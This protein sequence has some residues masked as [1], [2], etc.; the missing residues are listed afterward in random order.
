MKNVNKL[1]V[2]K[3]K[4]ILNNSNKQKLINILN[5]YNYRYNISINLLNDVIF[6]NNGNN[7]QKEFKKYKYSCYNKKQLINK[8]LLAYFKL[9]VVN[10]KLKNYDNRKIEIWFLKIAHANCISHNDMILYS[11]CDNCINVYVND[12]IYKFN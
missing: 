2:T 5:V 7:K 3:L 10:K 12:F 1:N 4:A 9:Q 11:I 6:F 8:I